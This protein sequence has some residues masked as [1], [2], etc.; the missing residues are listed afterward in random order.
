[1]EITPVGS[2]AT[3]LQRVILVDS[4]QLDADEQQASHVDFAEK[5]V[6]V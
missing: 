4:R 6:T 5:S 3:Q 1:L 2:K